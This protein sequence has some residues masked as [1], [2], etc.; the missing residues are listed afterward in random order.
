MIAVITPEMQGQVTRWG[1]SVAAWQQNVQD[2]RNFILHRCDSIAHQFSNCYPVT[3][4]YVV[5]V[6]VDPPGSGTVDF[7]TNHLTSFIWSGQYPGNVDI[8][9]SETPNPGYCFDHWEFKNHTPLPNNTSQA[10]TVHLV[11]TDSIVAHFVPTPQP[12][13]SPASAQICPG[14]TV[15]LTASQG[16]SYTWSPSGSALSCTTCTNTVASPTTTSTYTLYALNSS[17]CISTNTVLVTVTPLALPVITPN[18]ATICPGQ[19]VTLTA[20]PGNNFTWSGAGLS[21]ASCSTTIASPSSSITYTVTKDSVGCQSSNFV[22]VNVAPFPLPVITPANALICPGE[23]VTLT[24]TQGQNLVW[25]NAAGLSCTSCSVTIASPASTTIYT[26]TSANAPSNAQCVSTNT[27]SVVVLP[28]AIANFTNSSQNTSLPAQVQ[29]ASTSTLST[30]CAWNFGNGWVTG[31]NPTMTYSVAGTYTV[32]LIA[33]AT[34]GCSDTITKV[35]LVNDTAGLVMPTVFTPNGDGINDYFQPIA[36][37]VGN[38]A[39]TIF[40]RWGKSVFEFK[41]TSDKWSGQS[42]SGGSCPDGTYYYVM[43]A[44]DV[45]GKAYKSKGFITLMR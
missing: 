35:I 23:A 11:M 32:T 13:I 38:F 30:S 4:P 45:N 5:K 14:Q 27:V 21:C 29:F 18:N 3:G 6:N 2:L 25:S 40:D 34:N 15:A 12:V 44:Q 9:I 24:G 19:T 43:E 39:C 36:S 20:S 33:V 10:V 22:S 31:C 16:L 1:G 17:G 41:S 7:S 26:L 8:P 42:T 37:N 28:Q